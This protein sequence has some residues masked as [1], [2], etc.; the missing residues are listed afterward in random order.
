MSKQ[1]DDEQTI[2]AATFVVGRETKQL[3]DWNLFGLEEAANEEE[4]QLAGDQS[5]IWKRKWL[6]LCALPVQSET[7]NGQLDLESAG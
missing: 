1:V 6:Y 5:I 4:W 2:W 7:L 3:A